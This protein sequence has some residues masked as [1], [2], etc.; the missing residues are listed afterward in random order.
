ML[1]SVAGNMQYNG[2]G[3]GTVVQS[4][5]AQATY[6]ALQAG[7]VDIP[8]GS[9]GGSVFQLPM[10]GVATGKGY[11]VKA[12]SGVMLGINGATAASQMQAVATGGLVMALGPL[13]GKQAAIGSMVVVLPTSQAAGNDGS[14]EYLVFGD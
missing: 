6:T 7:I 5:A 11:M 1:V 10:G 4:L 3:G 8:S 13:P 12:N 14:V 9:A 2:V